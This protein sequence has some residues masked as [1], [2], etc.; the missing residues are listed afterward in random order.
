MNVFGDTAAI[1]NDIVSSSYYGMLREQ[2]IFKLEPLTTPNTS[3]EAGQTH[4]MLRPTMLRYVAI[5]W[6]GLNVY[7]LT[8][9]LERSRLRYNLHIQITMESE[10]TSSK[11]IFLSK[12]SSNFCKIASFILSISFESGS[13]CTEK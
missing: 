6:P 1:L 9:I 5:V 12:L 2:I 10:R 3:Q 4:N 8:R 13:F 7:W 11:L